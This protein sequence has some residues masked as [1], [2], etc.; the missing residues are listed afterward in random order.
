[1]SAEDLVSLLNK[2]ELQPEL[3]SAPDFMG[4]MFHQMQVYNN[5]QA[6]RL[7]KMR[8]HDVKETQFKINTGAFSDDQLVELVKDNIFNTKLQIEN[9]EQEITLQRALKKITS[10][11]GFKKEADKDISIERSPES[12]TSDNVIRFENQREIL[13]KKVKDL[14]KALEE[15]AEEKRKAAASSLLYGVRD[16]KLPPAM[17]GDYI[18]LN[19]DCSQ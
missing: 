12:E 8:I 13:V 6:D 10:L 11:K 14:E 5:Q 15:A 3:S 7:E 19:Y 16:A 17:E 18:T 4:K 2:L 9:V 1:M